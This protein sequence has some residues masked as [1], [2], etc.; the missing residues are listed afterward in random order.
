MRILLMAVPVTV[1]GLLVALLRRVVITVGVNEHSGV[2][3]LARHTRG[4]RVVGLLLGGVSA[5]LLL[6][7]GQRVDALG[8]VTALAPV[9]LGAGILLGTIAGELT[10]RPAVGIRRSAAV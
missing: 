4:W 2:V 5:V 8:R 1:V 9:A 3:Q 10:A 7:L 6:A